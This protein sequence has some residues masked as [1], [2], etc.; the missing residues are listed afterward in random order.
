MGSKR[1]KQSV[2]DQ[3]AFMKKTLSK[4]LQNIKSLGESNVKLDVQYERICGVCKFMQSFKLQEKGDSPASPKARK[5]AARRKSAKDNSADD[6]TNG[7]TEDI[8]GDFASVTDDVTAI[9]NGV[10][11]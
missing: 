6:V 11:S 8:E 10:A 9:A 4:R 2:E 5:A 1:V 7:A 3:L